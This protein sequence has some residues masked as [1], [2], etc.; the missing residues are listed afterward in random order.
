MYKIVIAGPCSVET[1]KQIFTTAEKLKKYNLDFLRGGAYK[2]R[3]KPNNFEGLGV[4]G[5]RLLKSAGDKINTKVI[6]EVSNKEHIKEA[7]NIGI[8]AYWIG[9]RTTANP[10]LLQEII[11]EIKKN[12][13]TVFIKNPLCGSYDLWAGGIDRFLNSNIQ[14]K[15]INRGMFSPFSIFRNIPLWEQSI[16]IKNNYKIDIITD[17]SH[18]SGNSKNLLN[19]CLSS[20]LLGLDGVM[21]EVHNNPAEART[22]AKQQ[23]TPEGL[24]EILSHSGDVITLLRDNIDL[25]DNWIIHLLKQRFEVCKT[26]GKQKKQLKQKIENKTREKAIINNLK[27]LFPEDKFIP[28]IME[29]IFKESKKIQ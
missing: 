26:I 15:A 27:T 8:D 22:D 10:F 25:F 21:V 7:N 11:N 16:K 3:T 4:E 2:P 18:I 1:K 28:P 20:K 19:I 17:P 9:A 14:V 23:I 6:T 5:L 12:K 29:S 13:K 24:A